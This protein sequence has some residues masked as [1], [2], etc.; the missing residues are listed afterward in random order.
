M[1]K[2]PLLKIQELGQSIWLDFIRRSMLTSGE[3]KQLIAD[4]GLRGVTSNPAIFEK[5]IAGSNDYLAAIGSLV[6]EGKTSDEIYQALAVE[7]VQKAADDFRGVFD[8]TDGRDGFVSLEVSPHLARDTQGTIEEARRLWTALDRPNVFIKVPATVE[9]LPAIEQLISEGINV[10]VTLLFGLDR[11]RAVAEPYIRGLERRAA[12]GLPIDRV[13]SVASFFLSRIDL[14]VDPLLEK[15]MKEGGKPTEIA[16]CVLGEAAI[17]SAK[18]A[19]QIYKEIFSSNRFRELAG[20]GSRTQRVLWA[21]TSAKNPAYSDVKYVEAL[22]GPDT[23]NTLP[24]ETLNAYRDHGAPALRLEEGVDEAREVLRLLPEVGVD[25]NAI[26]NQLEEEGIE[27]FSN[28][29]DR[30]MKAL[31]EKREQALAEVR[32]GG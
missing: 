15:V 13:A 31:D 30:L 8:A 1:N 9:G 11:Y 19:Y 25:I 10:N 26:T 24:V 16:A 3:L 22:I 29:F 18:I 17:A 21:S 27:K 5:A 7:D 32:L 6:H 4:D 14:L 28:P 12:T 23:V 2:N 20:K